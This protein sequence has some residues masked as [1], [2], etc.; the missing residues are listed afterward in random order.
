T[1]PFFMNDQALA[2]RPSAFRGASAVY[3]FGL[4]VTLITVGA[5]RESHFPSIGGV[6]HS[7]PP[8]LWVQLSLLLTCGGYAAIIFSGNTGGQIPREYLAAALGRPIDQVTPALIPPAHVIA[9][10]ESDRTR[11]ISRLREF[12]SRHPESVAQAAAWVGQN[13]E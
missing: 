8:A 9:L 5:F 6:I 12:F 7:I 11:A 4:A 10:L 2:V 13:N 1:Q 3:V